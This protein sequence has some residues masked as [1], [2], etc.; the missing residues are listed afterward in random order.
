MQTEYIKYFLEIAEVGSISKAAE[1]LFMKRSNLSACL[2]K[3]EEFVGTPLFERN[4]KGVSLTANGYLFY[5]WAQQVIRSYQAM[6]EEFKVKELSYATGEIYIYA[7]TSLAAQANYNVISGF[8]SFWP[9][10]SVHFSTETLEH[11]LDSIK[12]K[13]NSIAFVSLH[14]SDFPLLETYPDLKFLNMLELQFSVYTTSEHPLVLSQK[15]VSLKTLTNHHLLQYAPTGEA[16]FFNS[17]FK[18]HQLIVPKFSAVT[19]ILIYRKLLSSGKY[20]SIGLSKPYI[21]ELL[22]D[23]AEIPIREKLL[24]TQGLLISRPALQ[25]PQIKKLIQLYY[26]ELKLPIPSEL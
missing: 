23:F 21:P 1:N 6:Q 19:D 17:F 12:E 10:I 5:D 4:P 9:N 16:T 13:D 24:C 26:K 25:N 20:L 22:K 8:S 2:A 11:I 18:S 15:T 14:E 3:L 7:T